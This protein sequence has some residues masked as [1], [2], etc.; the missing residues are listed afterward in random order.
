[1]YILQREI[2][3]YISDDPNFSPIEKKYHNEVKALL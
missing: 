3:L 2:E 1:M